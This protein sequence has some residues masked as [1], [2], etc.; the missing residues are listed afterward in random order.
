MY[1]MISCGLFYSLP[2]F[3][4]PCQSVSSIIL[5]DV[6]IARRTTPPRPLVL[7]PS[8][9]STEQVVPDFFDQRAAMTA[10][11]R[12]REAGASRLSR[13]GFRPRT[14]YVGYGLPFHSSKTPA[15]S[16]FLLL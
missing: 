1:L 7:L 14:V 3:F 16:S 12:R 10:D 6:A 5:L 9:L 8:A 11:E 2:V 4:P 13:P 15:Q